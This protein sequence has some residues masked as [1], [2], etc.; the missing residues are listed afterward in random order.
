VVCSP[1]PR[2]SFAEIFFVRRPIIAA[3]IDQSLTTYGLETQ[4][5]PVGAIDII[6]LSKKY[7]LGQISSHNTT[8]GTLTVTVFEEEGNCIVCLETRADE[9]MRRLILG[10]LTDYSIVRT[11]PEPL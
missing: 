6:E 1:F 4:Q 10:K 3:D 2:L 11:S 7:I 8:N 5:N 9:L